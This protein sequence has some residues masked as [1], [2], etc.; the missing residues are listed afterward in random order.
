MKIDEYE[1]RNKQGQEIEPTK[2]QLII[3]IKS[4]HKNIKSLED[5]I[6]WHKAELQRYQNVNYLLNHFGKEKAYSIIYDSIKKK[7]EEKIN[8]LNLLQER[9]S[10]HFELIDFGNN[11][12]EF[13]ITAYDVQ[14]TINE[15]INEIQ[16]K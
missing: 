2:E 15:I 3:Y 13:M 14:E 5:N 7:K 10:N 4:L 1:F 9:L 12:C 16:K 11:Y 6:K 8:L